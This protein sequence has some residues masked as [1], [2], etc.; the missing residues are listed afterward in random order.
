MTSRVGLFFNEILLLVSLDCYLRIS[1]KYSNDDCLQGFSK[2]S[3][4]ADLE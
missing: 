4:F 2:L 3:N 1:P